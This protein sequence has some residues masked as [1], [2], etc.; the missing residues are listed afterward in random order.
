MV[1]TQV[2]LLSIVATNYFLLLGLGRMY[3]HKRQP[4]DPQH[5]PALLFGLV[6][7]VLPTALGTAGLGFAFADV[8]PSSTTLLQKAATMSHIIAVL[9]LVIFVA[10]VTLVCYLHSGEHRFSFSVLQHARDPENTRL[11]KNELFGRESSDNHN[12]LPMI[13]HDSSNYG[14]SPDI[15]HAKSGEVSWKRCAFI[16]F[17]SSVSHPALCIA[18]VDATAPEPGRW[19]VLVFVKI[20]IT[21]LLMGLTGITGLTRLTRTVTYAAHVQQIKTPEAK[22]SRV[23]DTGKARAGVVAL[24]IRLL[25]FVHPLCVVI[26]WVFY[27]THPPAVALF[28]AALLLAAYFLETSMGEMYV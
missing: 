11:S 2:L 16:F 26:Q 3:D 1:S 23:E 21:T 14:L 25:L 27:G 5:A 8:A 17:L 7:I 20:L 6:M 22:L 15:C 18:L 9:S 28:P 13:R 4:I 12:S 10:H 19:S 24:I